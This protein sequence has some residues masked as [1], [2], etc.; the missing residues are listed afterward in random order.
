MDVGFSSTTVIK[1]LKASTFPFVFIKEY[2]AT[3]TLK[4]DRINYLKLNTAF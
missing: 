1:D 3:L 4:K 2:K